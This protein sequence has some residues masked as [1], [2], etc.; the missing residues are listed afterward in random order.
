M[1]I[2]IVV[3]VMEDERRKLYAEENPDEP[4]LADLQREIR[5]L[6]ALI[7]ESNHQESRNQK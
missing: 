2:G 4:E 3:N 7:I 6:K 1:V 5:E